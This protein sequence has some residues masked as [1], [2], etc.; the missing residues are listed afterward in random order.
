MDSVNFGR[1]TGGMRKRGWFFYQEA[2][3]LFEG[4]KSAR[5]LTVS[6]IF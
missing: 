5:K 4:K 6:S 2:K 1:Q 3:V